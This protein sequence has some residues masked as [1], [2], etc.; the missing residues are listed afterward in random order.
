LARNKLQLYIT[1]DNKVAVRAIQETGREYKKTADG[2]EKDS[3]RQ[4]DS[5]GRVE[6]GAGRM[7]GAVGSL[8]GTV[9]LG[10]LALGLA[11]VVKASEQ[12]QLQQ[13][14]LQNA[15]KN[16]GQFSQRT[17]GMVQRAADS[18]STHGGFAV[19][20]QLQAITRFLTMTHSATKAV[21]DNALATGLA[22]RFGLDYAKAQNMVGLALTGSTGRLQRYLGVIQPV[23]TA[24]AA[25]SAAH[26][27]SVF[28]LELQ[29]KALGKAGP[30]W[31]KQ[32]ELLHGLTPQMVQHAQ[33]LDKQATATMALGRIQQVTR[34]AT[35]AFSRTTAGAVSNLRN[36][37]E[38][39]AAGIGK[40]LLPIINTL[41]RF[42]DRNKTAVVIVLGV[43]LALT[44]AV[45]AVSA[46]TAA[47]GAITAIAGGIATV[48][49]GILT[50]LRTAVLLL[51]LG[52][53]A[54]GVSATVAW[55]AATLGISL[56]I[57]AI[58]VIAT[59]FKQFKAVVAAVWNWLK[60]AAADVIHFIA[61]H[62]K[63]LASILG[64]PFVALGIFAATHFNQLKSAVG[65]VVRFIGRLF[66]TVF[67]AI[68]W[69]F[70]QAWQII[71]GIVKKIT[72]AIKGIIG[73][74]GKILGGIG[75]GIGSVAS[76]IGSVFGLHT[77]GLVPQYRASGGPIGSDTVPLWGTPGEFML[78]REAVQ[79]IGVQNLNSINATGSL[80]GAGA[81]SDE[82]WITMPV[83]LML[84]G[85]RVLTEQVVHTSAR[86]QAVS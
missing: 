62:W 13:A 43:V 64:G 28:A 54:M 50:G 84:P 18:L 71:S 9:G 55:A 1:A 2:I 81:G 45:G 73:I 32:Q 25:L 46:A 24:Q 20:A 39:L 22:R 61:S 65:G 80:A 36:S 52:F 82:K 37:F 57:A 56:L 47:W 17:M 41:V 27:V 42:L 34:G 60:T 15:L 72:G 5:F 79:N 3:K 66:S 33:L 77:G 16:T 8:M 31:L 10:G 12:L 86:K 51:G 74:P 70:Q 21:R 76:S 4:A 49:G 44:I 7:R 58:I 67:H 69:P 30:M 26:K 35:Q 6:K 38:N 59:H 29:S 53:E 63:L 11:D 23:K 78:R 83:T 19:P 68:A 85:G 48:F 14:Q 40:K 75:H